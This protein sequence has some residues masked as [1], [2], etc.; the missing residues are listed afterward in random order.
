MSN[1]F[2]LFSVQ[3]LTEV[4]E[5]LE[6]VIHAISTI[7]TINPVLRQHLLKCIQ[8]FSALDEIAHV[9]LAANEVSHSAFII[10]EGCDHEEVEERC[11]IASASRGQ[12]IEQ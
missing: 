2:G 10:V 5:R 4:T 8:A 6:W 1:G 11:S 7:T 9:D 12:Y 3:H